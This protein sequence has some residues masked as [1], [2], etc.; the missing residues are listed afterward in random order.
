MRSNRVTTRLTTPI[1]S[2]NYSPQPSMSNHQLIILSQLLQIIGHVR[3]IDELFLWLV[4]TLSWHLGIDVIQFWTLQNHVGGQATLELRTMVSRNLEL[5]QYVV[6]NPDVVGAIRHILK[7][8]SGLMPLPVASVFSQSQANLLAR[9]N[10]R[11][12]TCYFL[13]NSALLPPVPS[14]QTDS[15]KIYTPLVMVASLFMQQPP[16]P[17]LLPTIGHILEQTVLIAKKHGLLLTN[18]Q[19]LLPRQQYKETHSTLEH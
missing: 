15:Q 3:H 7:Q 13:C 9:H 16:V 17:R 2:D 1:A 8:R 12:W 18:G 5:P 14:T 6:I 4:H 10:L 11:Y 19:L